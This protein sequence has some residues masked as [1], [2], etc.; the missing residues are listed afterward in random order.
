[1][2]AV[3]IIEPIRHSSWM[4]NHIIIRKNI[5]DIRLCVDFRNLN[6]ELLKDNYPLPNMEH[7]LQ[8][9]TVAEMMP[10]LGGFSRCNQV[11]VKKEDQIKTAFTT[12]RGTYK[13]LRMPFGLTN[14]GSTFQRAM[15]YTFRYLSGKIIEIYHVDLTTI[16]KKRNEHI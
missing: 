3:G 12:P 13:Y 10:M 14:V 9:I 4:S 7:I 16:S 8:W 11:F 6:Q 1:M 15:D 5:G 2:V